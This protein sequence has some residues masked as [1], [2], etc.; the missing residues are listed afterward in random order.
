MSYVSPTISIHLE[1]CVLPG[2]VTGS[3]LPAGVQKEKQTE[4]Y[5]EGKKGITDSKRQLPSRFFIQICLKPHA[6]KT[7]K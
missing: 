1:T 5:G 7:M 2:F 3:R 4:N 6:Q